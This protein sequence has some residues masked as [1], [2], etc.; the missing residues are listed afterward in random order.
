[1]IDFS[2]DIIEPERTGENFAVYSAMP[3]VQKRQLCIDLLEE[4]GG[5]VVQETAK[6]ELRHRCTLPLGLHTDRDSVTASINYK[7]LVFKCYVCDAKGGLLWWIATNRG[8]GT[9][10][11]R[12]WLKNA[13]GIT[14]G[15]ELPKL[16]EILDALFHP[17]RAES[18]VIPTYS[19]KVLD[20][21]LGLPIPHP[22]LTAPVEFSGGENIGGRE[23]PAGNLERFKIGF[24]FRDGDWH[25]YQRIIIPIFWK[26]ELVGWQARQM[27]GPWRMLLDPADQGDRDAKG[28]YTDQKFRFSPDVPRDRILYG[29]EEALNGPEALVVESAFSVLRHAHHLP[30]LGTLGASV[31]DLQLPLLHRYRRITLWLDN[32]KAG[33][34]ALQGTGTGRKRQPGL[35]EK[36]RDYTEVRVVQSP[37]WKADPADLTEDEAADLYQAAKPA[38]L[39]RRPQTR[40]LQWYQRS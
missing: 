24:C 19:P 11:A 29:T 38:V 17:R 9:E 6:G 33:W 23:I 13:S 31:S 36:L 37:W 10:E 32:D 22:Y 4:F 8:E 7:K 35:I 18:R 14:D 27:P 5:E 20:Q 25:Y 16:L 40:D 12:R 28:D 39:W 34:N 15:L 2:T 3:D 1:L 26:G 30:V 21:W